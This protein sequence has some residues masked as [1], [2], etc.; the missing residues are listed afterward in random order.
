MCIFRE[1]LRSLNCKFELKSVRITSSAPST[2]IQYDFCQQYWPVRFR[3]DVELEQKLAGTYFSASTLQI[4]KQMMDNARDFD[5]CIITNDSYQILGR[6]S[7][8]RMNKDEPLKHPFM[9]AFDHLTQ[10]H[11][12]AAKRSASG[13]QYYGT[14]LSS[15]FNCLFN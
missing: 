15:I 12:T 11:A 9:R 13:E 14:G 8:S 7:E 5:E 10:S 3:E 6:A 4:F 2:R 1:I